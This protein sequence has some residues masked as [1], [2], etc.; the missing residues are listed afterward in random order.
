[1]SVHADGNVTHFSAVC[2]RRKSR[3]EDSPTY[4]VRY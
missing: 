3:V 1:V 2:V 4:R